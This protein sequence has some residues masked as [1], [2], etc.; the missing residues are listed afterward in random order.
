[1]S[2]SALIEPSA[3]SPSSVSTP[4]RFRYG[5]AAD[6]EAQCNEAAEHERGAGH[7]APKGRARA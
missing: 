5:A 7:D 3:A 2:Q 1:M 6:R 4:M